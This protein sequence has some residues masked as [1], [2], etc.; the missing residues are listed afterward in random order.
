MRLDITRR[1]F[2]MI[3]LFIQGATPICCIVAE[4]VDQVVGVC[5]LRQEEAIQYIRAHYNIEDFVY[6]NCHRPEQHGHL[7]HLLLSPVFSSHCK[8]FIKVTIPL[9][10]LITIIIIIGSVTSFSHDL[11][12]LS[13]IPTRFIP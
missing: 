11:F 13:I 2:K 7:Y 10:T 5:V 12:L 6:F 3:N 4:C 1:K 9:V 8:H